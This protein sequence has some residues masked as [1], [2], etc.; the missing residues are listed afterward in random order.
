MQVS[1]QPAGERTV[2]TDKPSVDIQ[3]YK[4]G[5][6]APYHDAG[7]PL[8]LQQHPLYA[9]ALTTFGA[10][11]A[12]MSVT[13]SG[14]QVLG[15]YLLRRKFFGAVALAMAFRGP[16]F[17]PVCDDGEKLEALR[18]LRKAFSPWRWR[19]LQLMPELEDTPG[20][21]QLLRKAGYRRIMTGTS[22]VWLDLQ[23]S[24]AELRAA[25]DGK[26]RNQLK[27]AEAE[28]FTVS[29]G[30]AKPKH[31]NWLLEKEALQ[32]RDRG[33]SAIPVG[34][35]PAYASIPGPD[36]PAQRIVSVTANE[37]GNQIAGA[38]FLLHGTSATYHIG[39]VGEKGRSLNAQNQVLFEGLL[40]LKEKGIKWLDLGGI[41]TG[42]QAGIARFKLGLGQAPTTFVG[43]FLG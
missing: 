24:E 33:Y 6:P 35:V 39:W 31:Y 29:V 3:P 21:R 22:T 37:R 14:K 36:G 19:F 2:T 40:A 18:A 20:N 12:T 28:T 30:G 4:P 43:T 10:D 5:A 9:A 27:K 38:L 17:S 26:W 16:V 15:G 34:L 42:E 7:G 11:V 23:R 32:Q 41:N 13:V 8:A 25:L 1:Q